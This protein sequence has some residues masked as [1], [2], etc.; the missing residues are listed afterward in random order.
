MVVKVK[1]SYDIAALA[2]TQ[3]PM[4]AHEPLIIMQ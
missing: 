4:G 1:H 3:R 2:K